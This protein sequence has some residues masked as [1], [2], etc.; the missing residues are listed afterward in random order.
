MTTLASPATVDIRGIVL[1]ERHPLIFS[2]FNALAV[3]Q[4]M[5]LVNDHDPQ[6]LR[7]QFDAQMP[8]HF[9]WRT[10]EAGPEVWRVDI[11]RLDAERSTTPCCGHCG[12]A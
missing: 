9:A 3:G 5:Q 10:V 7:H 6:P 11:T 4:S 12:G 8:G 2:S 1:R